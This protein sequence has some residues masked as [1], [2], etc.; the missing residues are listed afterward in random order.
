M[1]LS[2]QLVTGDSTSSYR[3]SAL[4]DRTPPNNFPYDDYFSL[5][6]IRTQ[7]FLTRIAE[8]DDSVCLFR[9]IS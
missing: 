5:P 9:G 6:T 8:V 3:L 7:H 2:M 1:H 4:F